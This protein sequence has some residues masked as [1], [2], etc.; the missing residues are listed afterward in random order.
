[1]D[2]LAKWGQDITKSVNTETMPQLSLL[3]KKGI[4]LVTVLLSLQYSS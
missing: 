1:M 4:N 3:E 2:M